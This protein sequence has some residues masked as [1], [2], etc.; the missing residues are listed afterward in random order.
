MKISL[1]LFVLVAGT[2]LTGL[3]Y[4][5][6]SGSEIRSID[7]VE[8][9]EFVGASAFTVRM[10]RDAV[11]KG[12][13][14][15]TAGSIPRSF[16][17]PIAT[18]VKGKYQLSLPVF[19][20]ENSDKLLEI[21]RQPGYKV[22]AQ[23]I[24]ET[25]GFRFGIASTLPID[26][27]ASDLRN[28]GFEAHSPLGIAHILNV[29]LEAPSHKISLPQSG[30]LKVQI[31]GHHELEPVTVDVPM[32]KPGEETTYFMSNPVETFREIGLVRQTF[33]SEESS[34][35]NR[36]PGQVYPRLPELVLESFTGFE[37]NDNTIADMP[38]Y[39]ILLIHHIYLGDFRLTT[40]YQWA[41]RPAG[42]PGSQQEGFVR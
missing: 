1:R 3:L 29:R 20:E 34:I 31:S 8:S 16:P 41:G 10:Y 14:K 4:A 15:S 7:S 12:W 28:A 32:Y 39:G 23:T 18:H 13:H 24:Q 36:E 40:G 38:D 26:V 22:H 17:E 11:R 5:N 2:M 35:K 21:M 33:I 27:I 30:V 25:I 6:D 37:L 42:L 9:R 19:H